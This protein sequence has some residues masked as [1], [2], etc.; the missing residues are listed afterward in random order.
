MDATFSPLA[1]GDAGTWVRI[2]TIVGL[3]LTAY[4]LALW[5]AMV[6]WTY[7]DAKARTVNQQAQAGAVALVA[8][9]N[10]PGL[11]LYL[12]LRPPDQ[13]AESFNRQ[14]EAEAFLHEIE[15]ADACPSCGRSI[16]EAFVACPYCRARLQEP[17]AAC[18]RNLRNG[19]TLCPY[20]GTDRAPAG[21]RAAS[22]AASAAAQPY[23]PAPPD[24]E[25]QRP[26]AAQP[27]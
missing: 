11:L 18:G 13:L 1:I 2:G 5:F 19:W 26:A 16:A 23:A 14:L 6:L 4:V 24:G 12:A 15:K 25:R 21:R 27:A 20:C 17:C 10:V 3:I 22:V 8:L 9:A 7:R